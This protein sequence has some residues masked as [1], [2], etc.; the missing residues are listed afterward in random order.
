MLKTIVC[1]VIIPDNFV[2]FRIGIWSIFLLSISRLAFETSSDFETQTGFGVMREFTLAGF[3]LS[4]S[5]ST[6]SLDETIPL[7]L[8]FSY[9]GSDLI[10][11]SNMSVAASATELL[12]VSLGT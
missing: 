11:F 1:E 10:L 2:P 12:G 6:K 4:S 3:S 5:C 8:E 9:T 7:N